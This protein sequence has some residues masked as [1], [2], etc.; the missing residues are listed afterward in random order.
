MRWIALAL[1][2]LAGCASAGL[3]RMYPDE[4]IYG[5]DELIR[6]AKA[7]ESQTETPWVK[8]W[9]RETEKLP[10]ISPRKLYVGASREEC[11]NEAKYQSLPEEERAKLSPKVADET[12]YYLTYYGQPLAYLR[13]Y[14]VLAKIGVAFKTAP[15]KK[16]LDFGYGSVG[17]LR[18]MAGLGTQ[19]VGVDTSAVLG[20]LYSE[21]GDQGE[22]HGTLPGQVQVYQGQ[23]P[24][25]PELTAKIGGGYDLIVSKNVLKRGYIH[26]AEQ[27]DPKYLVHL[28]VD[29]G[30]FLATLREALVP[31]GHLLIYNICPPPAP[32][33][34]PYIP[35]ADGHSPWTQEEW[36]KAGFRVLAL[37]VVDDEPMRAMGRV[38][39]W[40]NVDTDYFAHYTLVMRP[41]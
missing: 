12:F 22:I 10:R 41:E 30:T 18:L 3:P 39:K 20:A 34:K 11:V 40:E 35:W 4:E 6:D 26:P 31:G 1:T 32:P 15:P 8:Q 37:D 24:A 36:E 5:V 9:L 38:L 33:G 23:Y 25:E 2:L 27:V 19:A 7:L 14:E 29:D 16:M 17:Q 28:G 13:A 21:P